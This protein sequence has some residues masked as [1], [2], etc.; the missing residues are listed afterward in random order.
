MITFSDSS[1]K[2]YVDTA[3]S[4]G[5]RI[6]FIQGGAVDYGSHLPVPEAI[7]SGEAEYISAAVISIAEY[8]KDIAEIRQI[9]RGFYYVR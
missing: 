7:S 9:A 8:N 4:I 1:Q 5:G 6:T 2:N 3:R